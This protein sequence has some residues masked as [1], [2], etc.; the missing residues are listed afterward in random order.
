[1]DQRSFQRLLRRTVAIPVIMLVALAAILAGEILLLNASLHWVDHSDQVITSARQA[2]RSIVEMETG[3]RGYYLTKDQGFLD[4]Y[5]D[6]RSKVREQLDDLQRLTADN[7]SQQQRLQEVR[8]LDLRWIQWADEQLA[9]SGSG[10]PSAQNLLIGQQLMS[11][12]RDK[13]R[14]FVNAEERLRQKRS[15][16]Q[17]L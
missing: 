15:I 6:A 10:S 2:M 1:M 9:L 4:P 3:L 17:P 14:E 12:I 16:G 8:D 5:N 11:S 13:Q 7:P